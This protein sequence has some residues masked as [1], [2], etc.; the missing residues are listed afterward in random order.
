MKYWLILLALLAGFL[1]LIHFTPADAQE[2]VQQNG[3][4]D[5]CGDRQVILNR[6]NSG[7]HFKLQSKGIDNLGNLFELYTNPLTYHWILTVSRPHGSMCIVTFGSEW[8]Q[9][10][11]VYPQA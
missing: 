9:T 10:L 1:L 6:I 5:R 4:S 11:N 3:Q 7:A 2:Q 8:R